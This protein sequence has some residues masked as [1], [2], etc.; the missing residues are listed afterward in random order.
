M[1]LQAIRATATAIALR[2]GDVLLELYEQPHE[3][4]TKANIY[5]VVTEGDRAAEAV[6]VPALR[7]AFP[8]FAIVS[9][10]GGGDDAA[11]VAAAEYAW[12]IDPVDG[13]TNFAHNLPH[14]SVSIALADRDL[15]PV[16]G[17]VNGPVYGEIYSAARGFGATRNGQP[18]RVSSVQPL[19]QALLSSGFPTT[20]HTEP[21]NNLPQWE[22]VLM[23][24]RDLR[25]FA[26]AALELCWIA[27]GKLDGFWEKHI[28]S[29]DCLGGLM[30][31]EEAGG[32]I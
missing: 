11:T 16:V 5:D 24:A 15:R 2:A 12:H 20:R 25:R 7:A 6:I 4:A 29:W 9:E 1:D 14:F 32:R 21:D 28:H 10:E 17:V 8:E 18:I 3:E 13:T 23:A 19:N 22:A 30:C 26:S 31:V 27:A